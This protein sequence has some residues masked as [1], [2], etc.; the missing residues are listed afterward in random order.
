[1]RTYYGWTITK[2]EECKTPWNIYN[3]NGE[4]ICSCSTLKEAKD[5]IKEAVARGE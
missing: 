2:N 3:K 1:M 4:Y 5:S